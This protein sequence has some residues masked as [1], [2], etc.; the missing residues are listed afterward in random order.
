M[1]FDFGPLD[2]AA[3]DPAELE[4]VISEDREMVSRPFPPKKSKDVAARVP[5]HFELVKGNPVHR[6]YGS[7][8]DKSGDDEMPHSAQPLI[9][10]DNDSGLLSS[11]KSFQKQSGVGARIEGEVILV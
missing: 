10:R 8:G 11:I 5:R 2:H 9:I 4:T 6:K 3:F 1:D 7:G